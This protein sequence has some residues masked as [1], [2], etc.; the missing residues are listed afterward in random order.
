MPPVEALTGFFT[1]AP[2]VLIFI[3][4]LR[5][6]VQATSLI[7]GALGGLIDTLHAFKMLNFCILIDEDLT[8]LLPDRATLA[9]IRLMADLQP[10]NLS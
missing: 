7:I 3:Q 1:Q 8:V 2:S 9:M 10:K 6:G 5:G 4:V